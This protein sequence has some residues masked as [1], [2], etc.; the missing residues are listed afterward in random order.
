MYSHRD[1]E[2]SN[3]SNM[4][5]LATLS[6][7]IEVNIL[8]SG[9]HDET[10][11]YAIKTSGNFAELGVALSS[12]QIVYNKGFSGLDRQRVLIFIQSH[13][14]SLITLSDQLLIEL[15]DNIAVEGHYHQKDKGGNPYIDHVRNVANAVSGTDAKVVALLH[16]ILEDTEMTEFNLIERGI[17]RSLVNIVIILTRKK[18]ET[19]FEYIARIDQSDCEIA[20]LVK[21]ADLTDNLNLR[22]I[23]NAADRKKSLVQRYQKALRILNASK[24]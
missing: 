10:L 22:R 2:I 19:Y 20:K 17:P 13:L 18:T 12:M 5:K 7:N 9:K 6:G 14:S 11:I 4:R 24:S 1:F 8:R 15:A 23:K 16:D 21:I 3:I